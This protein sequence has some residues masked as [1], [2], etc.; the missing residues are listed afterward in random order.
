[1]SPHRRRFWAPALVAA[2]LVVTLAPWRASASPVEDYASYQPAEHCAKSAKPGTQVLAE[3]I[4]AKLGG[5]LGGI[6]RACSTSRSEHH[7]GRAFDWTLDATKDKDRRRAAQLRARLFAT[8]SAGNTHALARR[9]GVMYIIWNDHMWSAW[10]GFV[11]EDYLSSS[12]RSRRA[13]SVTLRHR[14]HLHISLTRAGGRGETS[15]YDGRLPDP[16]PAG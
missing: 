14:D 10:D 4:V 6:W 7:E 2:L 15:W 11:K 16:E 9:M 1:M 5:G 12:C 3:W 8:D 13:C